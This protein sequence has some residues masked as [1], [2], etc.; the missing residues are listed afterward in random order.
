MFPWGRW[1]TPDDRR[2]IFGYFHNPHVV[3]QNSR[4]FIVRSFDRQPRF[5]RLDHALNLD[6][7]PA[8]RIGATNVL[9]FELRVKL[10]T[11]LATG[12]NDSDIHE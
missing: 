11:L 1:S 7:F 3:G 2:L 9:A 4:G 10:I 8:K 12:T 5:F 6:N